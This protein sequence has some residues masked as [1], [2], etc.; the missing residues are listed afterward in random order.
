MTKRD[1]R[2]KK[3][4]TRSIENRSN[5][6]VVGTETKTII[7]NGKERTVQVYPVVPSPEN[8]VI[9]PHEALGRF[10]GRVPQAIP[11]NAY[12]EEIRINLICVAWNGSL[13]FSK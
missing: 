7:V 6:A 12:E 1:E 11:P 9:V 10:S 4:I 8:K 2:A 3:A 13:A 5:A